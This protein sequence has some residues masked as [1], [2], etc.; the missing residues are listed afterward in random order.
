MNTTIIA[1]AAAEHTADL[2]R[3]ADQHR[4]AKRA[5]ARPRPDQIVALRVAQPED[6][7]DVARLAQL[8]EAKALAGPVMLA[9]VNGETVA[10]LSLSDGRAVANPFVATQEAVSLLRLRA[11]QL[12]GERHHR[13]HR[14]ALRPRLA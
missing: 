13:W 1:A 9:I 14:R 8:D 2:R 5:P 3:A 6:E 7:Y 11:A 12:S 4:A 10:A